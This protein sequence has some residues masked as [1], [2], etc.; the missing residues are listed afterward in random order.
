MSTRFSKK[1][2]DPWRISTQEANHMLQEQDRIEI[3]KRL[4]EMKGPVRLAFFT[5]QLAGTCQYC[6]ETEQLLKQVSELSDK[7][8]LDIYN[9]VN[10]K[11]EVDKFGIDKIPAT[12]IMGDEDMG[13]RFYGIPSG[14]EFAAFL[15]IVLKVSAGE[16][17]LTEVSVKKLEKIK[18]PAHIQVF[19]TPTCPYC[20]GAAMVAHMLAMSNPNI[21][22]DVVEISEFPAM[23]QK[24]SVMGVPK[25]VVNEN[26]SFEGA[27]PEDQFVDEVA[28]A[29]GSKD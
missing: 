7:L 8:T 14:Y 24:Y 12:V 6:S 9:F 11:E 28:K 2:T 22:A 23:A 17:G 25:T 19:T 5:Q 13:I 3:K 15:E 26:H 27:L 4:E 21:K 29:A 18:D 20:P 16:S 1:E 10:D